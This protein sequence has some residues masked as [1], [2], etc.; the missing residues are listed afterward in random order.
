MRAAKALA[1]TALDAYLRPEILE[2]AKAE[3]AGIK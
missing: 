2:A 1:M 3:F